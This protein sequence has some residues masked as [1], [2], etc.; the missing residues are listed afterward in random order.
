MKPMQKVLVVY[1]C[2]VDLGFYVIDYLR[3]SDVAASILD[4]RWLPDAIAGVREKYAWLW[5]VVFFP[6]EDSIY[7]G[8]NKCVQ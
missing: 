1:L 8:D 3:W 5:F 2:I 6:D 4:D 7:K